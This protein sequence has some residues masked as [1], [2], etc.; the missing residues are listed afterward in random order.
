MNSNDEQAK[1]S[2]WYKGYIKLSKQART[3]ENLAATVDWIK[4]VPVERNRIVAL[5]KGGIHG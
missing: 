5:I 3:P 1:F 2:E 4:N